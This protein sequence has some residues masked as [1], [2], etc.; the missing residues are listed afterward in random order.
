MAIW[1]TNLKRIELDFHGM[2]LS[3]LDK[4]IKVYIESGLFKKVLD[5]P[6]KTVYNNIINI[7]K[8]IL[9]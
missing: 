8:H 2:L 4:M 9:T 1:L 5:I 3:I 7:R 6:D